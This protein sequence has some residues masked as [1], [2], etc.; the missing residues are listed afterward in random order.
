MGGLSLARVVS[1]RAEA[2]M[3]IFLA[4]LANPCSPFPKFG[5]SFQSNDG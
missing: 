2:Q 5:P 4:I 3:Q 1:A